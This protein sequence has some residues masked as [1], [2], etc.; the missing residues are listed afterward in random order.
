MRFID[1][2]MTGFF[3]ASFCLVVYGICTLRSSD[4]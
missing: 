3:I 1:T 4:K 2:M